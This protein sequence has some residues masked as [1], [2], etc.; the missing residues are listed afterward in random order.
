MYICCRY[1]K[2]TGSFLHERGHTCKKHETFIN[3][4]SKES[5]DFMFNCKDCELDIKSLLSI[6]RY[7]ETIS[8]EVVFNEYFESR[9]DMGCYY[10]T[11]KTLQVH[12]VDT[13]EDIIGYRV[14]FNNFPVFYTENVDEIKLIQKG[15]GLNSNELCSIE[16]E[17]LDDKLNTIKRLNEENE[18]LSEHIRLYQSIKNL[19]T[20][21]DV[22]PEEVKRLLVD[23]TKDKT[24]KYHRFDEYD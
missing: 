22:S 1:C 19:T 24:V 11:E 4:N 20:E 9:N 16:C 14:L 10:D 3:L 6:A 13:T 18:M 7:M 23:Y 17:L 5:M 8:F 15:L 21:Y 2:H 12:D